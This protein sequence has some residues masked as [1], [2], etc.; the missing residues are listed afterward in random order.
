MRGVFAV[1]E[2]GAFAVGD[3]EF[4]LIAE[5]NGAGDGAVRGVDDRGVFAA[6]V[7]GENALAGGVVEDG[8]GIGVGLCGADRFQ[9]FQVKDDRGVGAACADKAAAEGGGYGDAVHALGVGDV[10]FDGV[11][12]GIHDDDVRTVRNVNAAGVAIDQEIIPA[13]I[14]GHGNGFDDVI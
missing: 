5:R 13:F 2:D 4:G 11:G 1:D 8:V 14:P 9:G 10:A 6:A 12:V 7:E 3:R